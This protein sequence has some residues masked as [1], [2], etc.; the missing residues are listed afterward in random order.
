MF[1]KLF[2]QDAF[3][4]VQTYYMQG[5]KANLF[6]LIGYMYSCLETGTR[7]IDYV[8]VPAIPTDECVQL[9]A[10]SDDYC[11]AYYLKKKEEATCN[12]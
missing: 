4:D 1:W 10:L 7:R 9:M 2:R 11:K 12:S 3:G 6:A 5:S 8:H